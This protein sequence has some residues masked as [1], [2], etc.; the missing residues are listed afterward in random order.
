MGDLSAHF[1]REEFD[2]MCGCGAANVDQALIDGLEELRS[3]LAAP[4]TITSGVRCKRHNANVGG[5]PKSQHVL[6]KAADITV[7]GY[8]PEEIAAK[9]KMVSRFR[10]GGIG[11][12]PSRWFVHLDVR[13]GRA[14]WT[15]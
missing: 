5:S 15:G 13:N 9:A 1:S 14:R 2:C 4:I 7:R 8:T 3:L 11:V 6:G 12:Y 10:N